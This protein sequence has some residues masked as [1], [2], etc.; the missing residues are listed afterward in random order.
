MSTAVGPTVV[1]RAIHKAIKRRRPAARYVAPWY[2]SFV[3][4]LLAVT[5][6]RALDALIRRIAFLSPKSLRKPE[7]ITGKQ[8]S[9][10]A[11]A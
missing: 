5:P 1:A 10:R 4:A 9:T 11:V 3:F 2:G 7:Q 6:T 8:T